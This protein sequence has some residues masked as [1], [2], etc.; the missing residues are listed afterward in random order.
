MVFDQTH[1]TIQFSITKRIVYYL[2]FDY[3]LGQDEK[4]RMLDDTLKL[5]NWTLLIF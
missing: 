3:F 2:L 4:L 5:K 1:I